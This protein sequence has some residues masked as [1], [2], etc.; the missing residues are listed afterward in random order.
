VLY[1]RHAKE[2]TMSGQ[3][4]ISGRD[5]TVAAGLYTGMAQVTIPQVQVTRFEYTFRAHRL[6]DDAVLAFG[7]SLS[8][9]WSPEHRALTERGE[10]QLA[11]DMA[12]ATRMGAVQRDALAC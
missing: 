11:E 1:N 6:L 12:L 5:E 4:E 2:G 7:K 3:T 9:E 8:R 10:E